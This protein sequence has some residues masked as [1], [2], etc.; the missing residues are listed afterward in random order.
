MKNRLVLVLLLAGVVI[1]FALTTPQTSLAE[2]TAVYKVFLVNQE[3][4]PASDPV[5][6][7]VSFYDATSGGSPYW[8]ETQTVS[9]ESGLYVLQLGQVNAF[10]LSLDMPYYIGVTVGGGT[11][12]DA[13]MPIQGSGSFSKKGSA[14]LDQALN[15]KYEW[16][17][18]TA[19]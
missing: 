10:N 15:V 7:T 16:L 19:Q 1:M 3:G 6:I 13:R 4:T 18:I 8:S 2:T 12:K 11:E 14:S 5:D 9:P 17:D